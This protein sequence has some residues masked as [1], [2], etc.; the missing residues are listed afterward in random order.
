KLSSPLRQLYYLGGLVMTSGNK[1]A[2][3]THY[4]MEKWE[5]TVVLLNE[6][7]KE[8]DILFFPDEKPDEYDE[9]WI[10]MRKVAVPSFLTYFNQGPLNYEEQ[11]IEWVKDLFGHFDKIIHGCISVNSSDFLQ[12]Y[13]N[14]DY[15]IQGNFQSFMSPYKPVKEGWEKYTKVK[16]E[17]SFPKEIYAPSEKETALFYA[18]ADKGIVDRFFPEELVS[19]NL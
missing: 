11:S 6:I 9:E 2:I 3:E 8:Y 12:F 13:E 16:L 1:Q 15:L 14:L 17:N 18:M 10:K 7:E 5:D 19:E 4:T